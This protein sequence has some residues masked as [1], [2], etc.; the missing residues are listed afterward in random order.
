MTRAL[1]RCSR[2]HGRPLPQDSCAPLPVWPPTVWCPLCPVV[3]LCCSAH[4]LLILALSPAV[5]LVSA[6]C[7]LLFSSAL[8]RPLLPVDIHRPIGS[9]V[10]HP[11]IPGPGHAALRRFPLS[12]L[13]TAV[14]PLVPPLALTRPRMFQSR[15]LVFTSLLPLSGTPS[16]RALCHVIHSPTPVLAPHHAVLTSAF[17][18]P[19][20][21]APSW[22]V[23]S[24][25]PYTCLILFFCLTLRW[26]L[27]SSASV[28]ST[29]PAV[30]ATRQ[31][32]LLCTTIVVMFGLYR[33]NGISILLVTG[34]LISAAR[35]SSCAS[36][37]TFGSC[38]CSTALRS[39]RYAMTSG[40]NVWSLRFHHKDCTMTMCRSPL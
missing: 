17:Q 25:R 39:S 5:L 20:A 19:L 34:S 1:C 37:H 30:C 9:P 8:T 31:S 6:L 18:L 38:R 16:S 36:R 27:C 29:V 35:A 23:Q 3:V 26:S 21:T 22:M 10:P 14:H 4:P 32:G 24:G 28:V 33:I 13:G 12:H 7:F 2:V 11:R 40:A 15:V